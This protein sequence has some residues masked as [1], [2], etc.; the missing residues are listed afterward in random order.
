[1]IE[2]LVDDFVIW[3][4]RNK[5]LMDYK[6]RDVYEYAIQ[7]ILYNAMLLVITF[8]ISIFTR[9]IQSFI[10]FII[11]F[12][13]FCCFLTVQHQKATHAK[14][15]RHGR[16]H[17]RQTEIADEQQGK[18]DAHH[19][20]TAEVHHTRHEGIAGAAQCARRNDGNAVQRFSQQPDAQRL[21]RKRANGE[22]RRQNAE[23][24]RAQEHHQKS[25]YRHKARAHHD[26]DV[27]VA[28]GK[29]GLSRADVAPDERR[30]RRADTVARH[31]AQA[32]CRHG[33]GVCRD[34]DC[35]ERRN[36]HGRDDLRAAHGDLLHAD[37]QTDLQ[38]FFENLRVKPVLFGLFAVE[39]QMRV[40]QQAAP[41]H[42]QADNRTRTR[43]ADA[44]T[45]HAE[46]RNENGIEHHIE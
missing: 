31:V 39:P 10:M 2:Y 36:D 15:R 45:H 7:V 20:N 13:I 42:R 11:F 28:L 35:T 9:N 37:R 19:P 38:S 3:A 34:G 44:R 22:I 32:L 12:I 33:E 24:K 23:Y 14:L 29:V 18:P 17:A 43:R 27:A 16:P 21:R 40:A 25:R 30:R 4:Y 1:M 6:K 5:L 41:R 46:M 8:L 26:T